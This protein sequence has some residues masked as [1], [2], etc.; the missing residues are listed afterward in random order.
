LEGF[1]VEIVS[2]GGTASALR[3]GGVPLVD[4]SDFTGFPEM[5]DGRVKTMSSKV[6]AAIL[7]M[8]D[9]TEHMSALASH[10]I[11]PI[12][13]VVCN[14]Y[15]FQKVAAEPNVS[16]DRLIKNIDIGGPTLIRAAAKN[17][18]DVAVVVR[19]Q[20]YPGVLAE[21]IETGG[22]VWPTH[23]WRLALKAWRLVADYDKVISENLELFEFD[24]RLA[25]ASPRA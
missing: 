7:A 3:Q 2:T 20:D 5:L 6:A 18:Q 24:G 9:N 12:D 23:S 11:Q 19:P 16:L 10:R 4:I 17:W 14:L 8:R 22:E 25:A 13:M 1:G 15:P 21:M